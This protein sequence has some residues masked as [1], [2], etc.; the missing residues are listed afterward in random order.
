MNGLLGCSEN[1]RLILNNTYLS[2]KVFEIHSIELFDDLTERRSL[3][4]VLMPAAFHQV[5]EWPRCLFLADLRP[6][7][8]FYDPLADYLSVYTIIGRLSCGKLPQ[9]DSEGEHIS[10]LC[11]FK[12]VNDLG[13]H[14]LVGADL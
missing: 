9:N 12:T 6:Q 7:T 2:G 5:E 13:G 4:R 8:L 14:P 10:F 1:L 11:V 3:I